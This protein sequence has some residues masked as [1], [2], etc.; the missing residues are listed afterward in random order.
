MESDL[1]TLCAVYDAALSE[2]R[3]EQTQFADAVRQALDLC[4]NTA[5][6]TR[7]R[8]VETPTQNF[9]LVTNVLPAESDATPT[10]LDAS[11]N[12]SDALDDLSRSLK[13]KQKPK[14]NKTY[15]LQNVNRTVSFNTVTT[16]AY[17]IYTKEMLELALALDKSD[18]VKSLMQYAETPGVMSF[19][20]V[21][22]LECLLWLLFCGPSSFCQSDQCFGYKLQ[23]YRNAFPI[24]LSPYFYDTSSH[25]LGTL[26]SLAQLYVYA[27]YKDFHFSTHTV[28]LKPGSIQRITSLMFE[29]KQK[30]ADQDIS[31]WPI[32][33]QICIFCALY[34]QNRFC[35]DYA[36]HNI[37]T[38]I[39]SPIIIKDCSF[40]QTTVTIPHALF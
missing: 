40:I 7:L 28:N 23:K 3:A 25:E 31:P 13:K 21:T 6:N 37:Q 1:T 19:N 32:A 22:D 27:W 34:K 14:K 10:R 20:D 33:A 4:N 5:P 39:F 16:G 29:L 9:M 12:I 24:I 18:F 2:D 15:V 38:S 17:I 30:F 26:F 35:I 8:L 11:L 36:T